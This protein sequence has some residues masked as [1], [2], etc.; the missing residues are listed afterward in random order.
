[1]IAARRS[2]ADAALVSA[3]KAL[4]SAAVLWSGFRAISDDDYARVV[5]AERFAVAPN[6]DPTG[7]SWLPFPFYVYGGALAVFGRELRVA[8]A[9]AVALGIASVVL[10]WFSARVLGLGR[11]AAVVG[12]LLCAALPHSAY[13]GAATVP[14]L[15]T[16][17]LV[18]FGAA[19]LTKSGNWRL[20][21]AAALFIAAGSRYEAWAV[22]GLFAALSARDAWL[23]KDR[24]VGLAAG[25]AL[26][27]PLL[28]LL[29][30]VV[31]HGEATFFITRVTA[32]RAALGVEDS[33]LGRCLRTPSALLRGEPEL[34]L[35]SLV[36]GLAALVNR[37]VWQRLPWRFL[38]P[39]AGVVLLSWAGDVRGSAPTHHGERALLVAWFALAL[40]AVGAAEQLLAAASG[41]RSAKGKPRP[42]GLGTWLPIV[43]IELALGLTLR[44]TA[45]PDSFAER[46]DAV[47]I[48]ERARR[49][50]LTR[51]AIDSEDYAYLA[52]QA[53]FG[54][55][56]R[57]LI[58]DDHDPRKARTVDALVRD[59]QALLQR[60]R[61]EKVPF[62]VTS[63][64]RSPF[65]HA[66]GGVSEENASWLL[67][68]V[69]DRR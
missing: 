53:A 29:H 21:G 19:T 68:A 23:E 54:R 14:E 30:G 57:T 27:F 46:G 50:E 8:Q 39:A 22:A 40:G 6:V 3:F 35:T 26:G 42:R 38:G 52:V 59:P 13:L 45:R 20:W 65:A 62:L 10:L 58:L 2:W 41:A 5:I 36:V 47:D 28:W 18:V 17:A 69:S 43:L 67:I 4:V 15:P 64:A 24:V 56:E 11:A 33:L 48:G 55:P 34:F 12:A 49:R 60:L 51:L 61:R 1:M 25:V 63:R 9:V 7:S 66:I 32:Y 44:H 37:T 16:A 31:R